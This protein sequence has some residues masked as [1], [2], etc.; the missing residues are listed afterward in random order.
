M[1]DHRLEFEDGADRYGS[2]E[3]DAV[4]GKESNFTAAEHACVRKAEL[5]ERKHEE[6]VLFLARRHLDD[7]GTNE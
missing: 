1:K 3:R 2:R 4:K 7:E 5:R 6:E